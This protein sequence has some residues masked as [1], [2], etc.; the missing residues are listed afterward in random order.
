MKRIA[1]L[2]ALAL[3]AGCTTSGVKV[4]EQQLAQLHPGQSTWGDMVAAL[5]EPTATG[6]TSDAN[7]TATYTFMKI[8]TRPETFIPYVGLFVGG[9]DTKTDSVMLV[10]AQDGKLKN[11]AGSSG[12]IGTGMGLASGGTGK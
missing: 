12:G 6:F 5:G 4:T 10:F 1:A 8:S 3:L 2:L 7:R 9:A 11:W